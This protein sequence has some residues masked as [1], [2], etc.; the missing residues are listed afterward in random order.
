MAGRPDDPGLGKLG[1]RPLIIQASRGCLVPV[2]AC[3]PHVGVLCQPVRGWLGRPMAQDAQLVFQGGQSS[4]GPG[5]QDWP[6]M[7]GW[8]PV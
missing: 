5:C 2:S 7:L 4:K 3:P 6:V 1:V 8:M